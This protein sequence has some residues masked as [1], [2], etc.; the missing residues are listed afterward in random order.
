MLSSRSQPSNDLDVATLEVLE[1]QVRAFRGVLITVRGA[2]GAACFFFGRIAKFAEPFTGLHGPAHRGEAEEGGGEAG[3]DAADV[4][5]CLGF[6][7]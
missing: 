7:V 4:S 6:F 2:G 3:R 5:C 1:E